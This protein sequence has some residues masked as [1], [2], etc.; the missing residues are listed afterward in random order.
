LEKYL[1]PIK[2]GNFQ[3]AAK[4][5][6]VEIQE[7]TTLALSKMAKPT[8]K[9]SSPSNSSITTNSTTT[10][11]QSSRTTNYSYT[12][13]SSPANNPT[14]TLPAVERRFQAI[15]QRLDSLANRMDSIENLFRQLKTNTNVFTQQLHQ[16]SSDLSATTSAPALC[17]S[18]ATKSQ[19]LS[20]GY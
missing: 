11:S 18:P 2:R 16:L 19:R 17:R 13:I 9:R 1:I 3:V 6:P 8:E 5:I 10:S 14:H 4:P 20:E 7:H 12:S 15:E